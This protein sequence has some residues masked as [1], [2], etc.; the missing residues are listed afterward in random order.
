M[1]RGFTRVD[2]RF[3]ALTAEMRNGFAE[4]RRGFDELRRTDRRRGPKRDD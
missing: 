1:E 4:M 3:E 2:E